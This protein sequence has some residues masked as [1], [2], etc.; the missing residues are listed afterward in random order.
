MKRFV[1]VTLTS[2]TFIA[3]A[4]A[5]AHAG[6]SALFGDSGERW[7]PRGRLPDFSYAGFKAGRERVPRVPVVVN[8]HDFGAQAGGHGDQTRALQRAIDAAARRGGGAVMIPRGRYRIEGQLK[9][10]ESGVVLRGAGPGATT[11]FF[12]NSLKDLHGFDI[13]Y[14]NGDNGL[15]QAGRDNNDTFKGISDIERSSHRGDRSITLKRDARGEGVRVGS[16]VRISMEPP[17]DSLALWNHMHNNQNPDPDVTGN[18][19]C[20]D[21]RGRLGYWLGV[22]EKVD[23]KHVTFDEPLRIDV[24]TDWNPKIEIVKPVREVGIEDLRIEF[25]K[26]DHKI[27][28]EEPGYNGIGLDEGAVVD[29]WVKNVHIHNADNGI[30]LSTSLRVTVKDVHITADRDCSRTS[31]EGQFGCTTGHHALK[32][33]I[34]SLIEDVDIDTNYIHEMTFAERSSGSVCSRCGGD[35]KWS[36]DQHG[37]G[38]YENLVTQLRTSYDFEG[39]G[40]ACRPA[41]GARNVLWGFNHDMRTPPWIDIQ[42]TVVGDLASGVHAERTANRGW[43]EDVNDADNLYELQLERRLEA[44]D[45]GRF[46]DGP[47]GRR[48][49]FA[50]SNPDRFAV[51]TSDNG[52]AYAIASTVYAMPRNNALGARTLARTQRLHDVVVSA[53]ARSTEHV[54]GGGRNRSADFALVLAADGERYYYALYTTAPGKSGIFLAT[55][56]DRTRLAAVNGRG[57]DDDDWHRVSFERNGDRLVMKRDDHVLADVHDDTLGAGRAGFGSLNDAALFDDVRVRVGGEDAALASDDVDAIVADDDEE[58]TAQVDADYAIDDDAEAAAE[59]PDEAPAID[60]GALDVATLPLEDGGCSATPLAPS[61]IAIVVVLR[62]RRQRDT[63]TGAA[64]SSTHA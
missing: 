59:F 50:E 2:L 27:H 51:H 47:F 43:V 49:A 28:H 57:I 44:E 61:A 12:V 10:N 38:Q 33:G 14:A 19:S 20:D 16:I 64:R 4:A 23:G 18:G 31:G 26:K 36:I 63:V 41:A 52:S 22:V 34:D 5:T 13:A 29:S 21:A 58:G 45:T 17:H 6:G 48:D 55:A 15:I 7:Q 1:H 24:R 3:L 60:D 25:E 8:A 40:G 53:R 11:L 39:G 54:T 35:V 46:A 62:R 9:L 30:S 37:R 32:A 42:T 56:R